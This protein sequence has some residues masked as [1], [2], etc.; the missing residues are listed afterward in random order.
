MGSPGAPICIVELPNE[1]I[2]HTLVVQ[3]L[4][5]SET[6]WFDSITFL[7]PPGATP[8]NSVIMVQNGD[9]DITYVG[10]WQSLTASDT[11]PSNPV[12]SILGP[13]PEV[14]TIQGPAVGVIST[15]V[16]TTEVIPTQLATTEVIPTPVTVTEVIPTP[17]TVTEVI[18]T[19]VIITVVIPTPVTATEVT[20]TTLVTVTEV[21]PTP[22]PNTGPGNV[23]AIPGPSGFMKFDFNGKQ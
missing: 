15:G 12:T 18:P 20:T 17:V 9:P 22:G 19:P 6:F 16:A 21:I 8:E 2:T 7:P 3:T 4:G 23:A 5:T 10:E 11:G 13:V 1:A 14:S